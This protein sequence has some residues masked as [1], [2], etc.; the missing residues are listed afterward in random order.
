MVNNKTVCRKQLIFKKH[1]FETEVT[2]CTLQE[3]A[4]TPILKKELSDKSSNRFCQKKKSS[5]G[6]YYA[7]WVRQQQQDSYRPAHILVG[8][9]CQ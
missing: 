5:V 1:L 4:H 8:K 7:I 2:P 9:Q 6:H 3:E